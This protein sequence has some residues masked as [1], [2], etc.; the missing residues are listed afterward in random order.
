VIASKNDGNKCIVRLAVKHRISL[1]SQGAP[2]CHADSTVKVSLTGSD[3][4]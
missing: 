1:L 4:G 2:S 3:L